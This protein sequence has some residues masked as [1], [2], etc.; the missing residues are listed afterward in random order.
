M[1]ERRY[2]V[3]A[4]VGYGALAVPPMLRGDMGVGTAVI[5]WAFLLVILW[6]CEGSR[7]EQLAEQRK[8]E[9]EGD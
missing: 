5:V 3:P 1:F 8:R 7:R 4:I 9:Q 6:G 2:Y